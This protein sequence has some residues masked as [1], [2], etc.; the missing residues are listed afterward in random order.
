[1]LETGNKKFTEQELSIRIFSDG[2]SF[3]TPQ[4]RKEVKAGAEESLSQALQTAFSELTLLRTDYEEVSVMA[5]YP[6][7]RIPLDEF[8]SEEAHALYQLTFGPES[9]QGMNIHYEMLPA[10]EAIEVFALDAQIEDL[11][12]RY[13]P[14]ASIHSHFGQLM[15]RMLIRDKRCKEDNRR[16]YAYSNGRQL[17]LFTYENGRLQFANSFEAPTLNNQLYFLLYVW[18]Q[19]NLSQTKDTCVLIEKNH[20]LEAVLKHYLRNIV[21]LP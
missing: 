1:M 12:F 10:L 20:E 4:G 13:Y 18:K 16:L 17:F 6:S 5:D 8:R 14:H 19:L 11:V 9:L 2:F 21:V 3:S 7:T 15:N